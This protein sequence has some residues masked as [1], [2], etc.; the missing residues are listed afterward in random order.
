MFRSMKHDECRLSD[1][2][3][4]KYLREET[5]GVLSVHGDDGYP[6][7]VPMNYAW[8]NGSILLHCASENSHR[9]DSL[10]RDGKV[11]FT[12]VPQHAL[13]REHWS[14]VY[15]SV[16]LFGTAQIITDPEEKAFAMEAF[17]KTLAPEKAEEAVRACDPRI[18]EL[19]ML[20]IR[21]SRVTGKQSR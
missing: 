17:L 19:I 1:E 18:P 7:G 3:A 9:L 6:Y 12:V 11:C 10:K 4:V 21:P 16:I 20:R 14:T 2:A 13:D 5:W 15:T 8:D